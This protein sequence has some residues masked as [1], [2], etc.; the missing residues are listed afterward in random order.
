MRS[1]EDPLWAHRPHIAGG[2]VI[3]T[4]EV[5]YTYEWIHLRFWHGGARI[6]RAVT[7][8]TFLTVMLSLICNLSGARSK[9]RRLEVRLGSETGR[10]LSNPNLT[11]NL[12]SEAA[13]KAVAQG[14]WDS[15]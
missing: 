9:D 13:R 15:Y 3:Q 12:Q 1:P 14:I 2:R 10:V 7:N 4:R 11:S 6:L 5:G 8:L